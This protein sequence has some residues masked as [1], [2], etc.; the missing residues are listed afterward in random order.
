MAW[1]W[2]A[3]RSFDDI[4]E[5]FEEKGWRS[6][7]PLGNDNEVMPLLAE[8]DGYCITFFERDS[9]TGEC[10]FEL[11]DTARRRV[12][13]VQGTRNIPRIEQAAKLLSNYGAP[14]GELRAPRDLPLYSLPMAPVVPMAAG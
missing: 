12:V 3:W 6:K 11:R 2:Q 13:F 7:F 9:A 10:W 5:T 1:E 8:S 14:L 4:R